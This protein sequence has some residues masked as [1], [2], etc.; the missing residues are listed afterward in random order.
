MRNFIVLLAMCISWSAYASNATATPSVNSG[1]KG[2]C[3][4][5]VSNDNK[6][7]KKGVAGAVER[8]EKQA[9]KEAADK[10][11]ARIK[12]EIKNRENNNGSNGSSN[13]NGSNGSTNSGSKDSNG[14]NTSGTSGTSGTTGN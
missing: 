7:E 5:Y 4:T 6:K 14:S 11:R 13:S 12:E 3:V 2:G 1:Q 8:A 10:E 9:K